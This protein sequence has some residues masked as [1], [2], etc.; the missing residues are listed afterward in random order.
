MKR[1]HIYISGEV[2]GVFFRDSLKEKAD[3][4]KVNGWAK[5]TSDGKVEAVLEGEEQAVQQLVEW[6]KEGSSAAKVK[7]IKIV[8]EEV[9]GKLNEFEVNY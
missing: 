2:Q 3:Q 7:N 6:C 9:E 4:L 5:N 1:V 8:D